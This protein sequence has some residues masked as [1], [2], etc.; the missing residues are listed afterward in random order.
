MPKKPS[1]CLRRKRTDARPAASHRFRLAPIVKQYSPFHRTRA[2]ELLLLLLALAVYAVLAWHFWWVND[3]AFITF[4]YARNLASGHGLTYNPGEAAPVEGYSNLLWVLVAALFEWLGMDVVF[5]APLVSFL[6]GGGLLLLVWRACRG[7]LSFD[8]WSTSAA[9]LFLAAF[10]PYAVWATSGLE[11]ML[12]AFFLFLTFFL[13]VLSPSPRS[14]LWAGLAGLG[15]VLIRAEGIG[16]CLLVASCAVFAQA[17]RRHHFGHHLVT[18]LVMV[19]VGSVAQEIF[20]YAYY[21]DWLP[22][23]I[24]AKGSLS[25]W[26]LQRGLSYVV[27]FYLTFVSSFVSL[28]ATLYLLRKPRRGIGGPIVIA[29]WATVL[30][31]IL[32][33]GDFM[34]MGRFLVPALPFL[35]LMTGFLMQEIWRRTTS[36]RGR[37]LMVAVLC[38]VLAAGIL[39]VWNLHLVP[40]SVRSAFHF[41]QNTT[42]F[43]SETEQWLI[44]RRNSERWA[45][46]GRALAGYASPGDSLVV[47]AIGNIGYYSDLII[48]DTYGLVTRDVAE[49]T[50]EAVDA[51][52]R[53]ENPSLGASPVRRS[54]GHDKAIPSSFFLD[55]QPTYIYVTGLDATDLES[56]VLSRVTYFRERSQYA[57]YVPDVVVMQGT[58]PR[59]A[60]RVLLVVRRLRASE[61]PEQ[62]WSEFVSRLHELSSAS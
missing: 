8:L 43:R 9:S 30:Y 56:Q 36:Y 14:G 47:G 28:P 40:E 54:P 52:R 18:F 7:H 32:V 60:G 27:V 42:I 23:T 51:L 20:R 39:P 25:A 17:R 37:A 55:R 62:A 12:F 15:V 29:Y 33:G 53:Q 57:E 59:E 34:A 61:D 41:R 21:G 6:A 45:E 38:A 22:N 4:R 1:R 5:W 50:M 49:L 19:L 16:W 46:L 10:P 2:L 24:R 11:T 31:A 3:D 35:A 26:T 58:E 13:L 44:M 48:Y